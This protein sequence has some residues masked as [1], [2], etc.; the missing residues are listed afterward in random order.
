MH[1][2]PVSSLTHTAESTN[3]LWPQKR[4]IQN[5][6][7]NKNSIVPQGNST[8]EEL[9]RQL[10]I[11]FPCRICLPIGHCSLF[12]CCHAQILA[13]TL[14]VLQP[15]P[16]QKLLSLAS[17]SMFYFK[18][19]SIGNLV[20]TQQ[21]TTHKQCKMGRLPEVDNVRALP[22]SPGSLYR[23]HLKKSYSSPPALQPPSSCSLQLE[24]N[25]W[26]LFL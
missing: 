16:R 19:F 1:A 25:M 26:P 5:F 18:C 9:G 15:K 12:F 22:L 8:Q 7:S 10:Q 20:K 11:F 4:I 13:Y 21:E 24:H 3:Q 23:E 17:F 2:G 6:P 14:P